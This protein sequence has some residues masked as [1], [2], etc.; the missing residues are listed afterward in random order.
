M[1]QTH[2][3][4]TWSHGCLFVSHRDEIRRPAH[5]HIDVLRLRGEANMFSRPADAKRMGL[6]EPLEALTLNATP[7]MCP[8]ASRPT[9]TLVQSAPAKFMSSPCHARQTDA[10]ERGARPTETQHAE[11]TCLPTQRHN[12]YP[13]N[14]WE[15]PQRGPAHTGVWKA[16]QVRAIAQT[17]RECRP[18]RSRLTPRKCMPRHPTNDAIEG[19]AEADGRTAEVAASLPDGGEAVMVDV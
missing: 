11:G 19:G 10:S 1:R 14:N 8:S 7:R 4:K 2:L 9:E 5:K 6:R 16:E 12:N 17:P 15:Q 13:A 3:L 18:T